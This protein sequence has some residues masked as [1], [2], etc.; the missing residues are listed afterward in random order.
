MGSPAVGK[1]AGGQRA[2]D[3]RH[4]LRSPTEITNE[5]ARALTAVCDEASVASGPNSPE[6]RVVVES[7]SQDLHPILR[8]EIYRIAREA[9]RN[10]FNHS[11][12]R[13]IEAEITYGDRL[14]RL[15]IRDD[16][17]GIPPDILEAGR[18][19]HYGLPGI[20]ERAKQIGGQL[21]IWSSR[22]A[23]TEIELSIPGTIAYG[24]TPAG[25][26]W[27]LFRKNASNS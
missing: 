26:R 15:R 13:K 11:Q 20:R 5:L 21:N 22:G 23:G 4:D 9:L 25:K 16:G 24:T 2:R 18:F 19:G 1:E 27:G 10:A 3:L 7:P 14:L 17:R 8:D 12:A 6:F